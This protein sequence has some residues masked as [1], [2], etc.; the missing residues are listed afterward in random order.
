M[1]RCHLL[2]NIYDMYHSNELAPETKERRPITLA[3][4][5]GD[6]THGVEVCVRVTRNLGMGGGGGM[7]APSKNL[8]RFVVASRH[9]PLNRYL[10]RA[11]CLYIFSKYIKKKD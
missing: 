3:S 8:F 7:T 10:I 9:E 2:M 1:G 5:R 4:S 6:T 11:C